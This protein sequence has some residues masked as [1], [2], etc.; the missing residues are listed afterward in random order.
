MNRRKF[1]ASGAVAVLVPSTLMME[2]CAA[3]DLGFYI[4]TITGSLK[5][6]SP[7]LPDASTLI[8]K[9][10]SIANDLNS[11]YS[12]GDFSSTSALYA[13]LADVLSQIASDAG[14]NTP[15]IQTIISIAGIALMTV[16][17]IL[18]S[19]APMAAV[20]RAMTTATPAQARGGAMI[21][22]AVSSSPAVFNALRTLALR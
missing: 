13:S 1:I 17:N 2:G 14:V 18:Q 5:Q 3:K 19:Q 22:K 12:K 20:K 4:S 21:E 16:A 15:T 7:L 9:A 6:L 10:I 8:A 11:A